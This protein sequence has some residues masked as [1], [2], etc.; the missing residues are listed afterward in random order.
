MHSRSERTVLVRGTCRVTEAVVEP[1]RVVGPHAHQEARITF[2]TAGSYKETVGEVEW[3]CRPLGIVLM[4]AGVVHADAAGGAPVRIV[5]VAF[6]RAFGE[7]DALGPAMLHPSNDAFGDRVA[8][9]HADLRTELTFAD[10]PAVMAIEAL[11]YEALACAMRARTCRSASL[12]S[13]LDD[14]ELYLRSNVARNVTLAGVAGRFEMTPSQLARGFRRRHGAGIGAFVRRMRI[15]MAMPRL[16]DGR[17]P[18]PAIAADLGFCD[19]SHFTRV[20]KSVVGVPPIAIRSTSQS[21]K[22]V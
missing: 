9:I 7:L 14:V 10:E 18:L 5:S 4:P 13:K 3:A 12:D 19:A 8:R 6:D 2:V 16:R 11:C 22:S 21:S 15:E 1:R 17:D 20:F